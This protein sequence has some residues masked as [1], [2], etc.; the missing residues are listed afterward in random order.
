[1]KNY[2]LII[3]LLFSLTSVGQEE[4]PNLSIKKA[5]GEINLDGVLDEHDWNDAEIA[6]D[7]YQQFPYDTSLAQTKTEVRITYDENFIYVGAICFDELDGKYVIQSLKR[8]F[9]YPISDAFAVFLDPF[10]DQT[11]GF[12]F[13]VN[14]MGVQREGLLQNGGSRGVTTAWD[15]KWFSKVTRDQNKWIVEMAIPFK[16]IRYNEGIPIWGINFSRNDLKRNENSAWSPVPRNFNIAT[17]AFSGKLNWDEA[18]K[19]AGVNLSI[20]PYGITGYSADFDNDTSNFNLNGG[21]DAKVAVTSSLNLDI[22]INPDF[23][24]VEV[25][26]QQTNLTRFNL[27]YPEKRQFFIENSDLFGQFGFSKIRP[28]FSRQIG[29]NQGRAVPIIGGLRLSGKINENWRIGLMNIQTAKS[30]LLEL[31]DSNMIDTLTLNPDN[32]T[33]AAAQ[34]KV[35]KRS[36]IGAIIVNKQSFQTENVPQNNY[37]RIVGL[38]YNLA[39]ADN[40]WMGKIFYHHSFYNNQE[41]R[42]GAHASWLMYNTQKW[43]IHWNHEYVGENYNAEVGFVQR[44][45]RTYWRLE[46]SVERKFYPKRGPINNHGPKLYI[47]FFAD[48]SFRTS[49]LLIMPHYKIKFQNTSVFEMHY[50]EMFTRLLYATD[51]TFSGNN[52]IPSGI[53][54]YRNAMMKYS[55]DRRKRVNGNIKIHYGKHYIGKRFAFEGALAYRQQPW[56]ILS[57]KF[58]LNEIRMPEQY[59]NATIFLIGPKLELSFTKNLFWSTFVQFNSQEQNF[60]INS[61]LQWR[62]RPMS[63]IYLVYTDNY[64]AL[65]SFKH[66]EYYT[67]MNTNID[68]RKGKRN[69]AIVFKFVYWLSI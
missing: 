32:F 45:N 3:A 19:K 56:G 23:S 47:N 66:N 42:S 54:R 49:D 31:S 44:S 59:Q 51:V 53:Y 8:D 55:S 9:S 13:A 61:R 41:K 35:F 40:K 1:M 33:V 14:P 16:T 52:P 36:F 60:N 34:R 28:F 62:F 64:N 24:Q 6:K 18:P 27:F 48:S 7:F 63:D 5:K 68:L 29:L 39:S 12:S 15:N 26:A 4:K 58:S 57:M 21:L 69:R 43:N 2:V 46:P 67:Q 10:G 50:H 65:T 37:N 11:N 17:M 30:Q 25:D 20:I 38:D 22:T